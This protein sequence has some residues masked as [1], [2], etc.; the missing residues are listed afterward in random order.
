MVLKVCKICGEEF[1]A[2]RK[3][4]SYCNR[5]K[6]KRCVICGK[7]FDTICNNTIKETCSS[8]CTA[9]LIKKN[10]QKSAESTIRTCEWCGKEFHPKS[11]RDKYCYSKHYKICE[12]CGKEFEIDVRK[13]KT[14]KTCSIECENKL[15]S[16]NTDYTKVRS[17]FLKTLQDK[18]GVTNP[19]QIEGSKEKIIETNLKKYGKAW[20]TQTEE[21]K[22]SVCQTSLDN[23]GES[24]FLK[25]KDVIAKRKSTSLERYGVDNPVKSDEVKSRIKNKLKSKYGIENISQKNISNIDEWNLF[26]DDP[27]SYISQK[28]NEVTV[29]ELADYFGV[30]LCSIYNNLDDKSRSLIKYSKSRMEEEVYN[31]L[32]N[33]NNDIKIIMHSRSI[34]PPYELD[35]YLPDFKIAIECNPTETHNAT[36]KD[37]WGGGPKDINYHKM[38]TDICLKKGIQLFHIFGYEWKFKKPII[39][40]MLCN[41]INANKEKVY[42][43]NCSI[44]EVN[45]EDTMEFLIRNHRQQFAQSS[46]RIGL[47]HN[48]ELVSIMTFGKPRKTIGNNTEEYELIRFCSKMNTSVIGGASKLFKYFV[49]EYR[50]SSII[51]Y[52]DRSHT[53]G[54]LYQVLGF[55]LNHTSNPN[56]VWV[57]TKSDRAL[58]RFQTQKSTI[59]KLF[60]DVDLSKTEKQIMIEHGFVQVFDS[61]TDCWIWKA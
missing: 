48:D 21:Y 38:K 25:N 37:V 57:D 28:W 22:Q 14:K 60:D 54:N 40:S 29:Q 42:A 3:D 16:I 49:K 4:Q 56:Y 59:S 30:S 9:A 8:K 33:I 6:S 44:K 15:R 39:K 2:K 26:V 55:K 13:D 53:S 20:Y 46:I 24:H 51:S 23:Y 36:L 12:V 61:G 35:L 34:I 1:E 45:S 10:R 7:L 47:F 50:P 32:K 5:I 52:A 18:Y 11:K 17:T 31:H 27:Y 58:T 19:M 43:R 41:L